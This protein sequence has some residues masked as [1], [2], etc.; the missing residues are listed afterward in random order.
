MSGTSWSRVRSNQRV[1]RDPKHAHHGRLGRNDRSFTRPKVEG[2][3]L[4]SIGMTR[5]CGR[6]D[7]EDQLVSI[8]RPGG[9]DALVRPNSLQ[10]TAVHANNV[11]LG[12]T[13]PKTTLVPSGEMEGKITSMGG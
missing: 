13:S 1:L 4:E 8:R 10:R 3:E 2:A 6:C 9:I 7:P 11:H 5:A 12:L